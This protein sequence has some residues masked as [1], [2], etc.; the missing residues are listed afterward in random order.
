MRTI[1]YLIL[2]TLILLCSCKSGNVS[3]QES[4]NSKENLKPFEFPEIPMMYTEPEQRSNYLAKH[5]WENFNFADT[6]YVNRPEITEQAW[7]DYVN[8]L[9]YVPLQSA[10][11]YLTETFKLAEKETK[12]YKYFTELA[13]KYLYDP[14]SPFR[15]EE[16]YIAVLEVMIESKALE[17]VDKIR[18]IDRLET[19]KKNRVGY[20]AADF[21][22]T[23]ESGKQGS[24]YNIKSKYTLVYFNNPGCHACE[25]TIDQLK[26]S[27]SITKG[28]LDKEITILAI[29]PDEELDEWKKH[30]KDFPKEWINGYDKQQT[31]NNKRLYDLKAIPCLYFLD[32][33]KTVLLKDTSVQAIEEYLANH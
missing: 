14:N 3:G 27:M 11:Q 1:K 19:A 6:N 26:F 17:D 32:K 28:V 16:Y 18:P 2:F 15:N 30:L 4:N 24:L 31:L 5:Y 8:I 12:V 23:T 21:T 20:K 10:Q 29:Y 33:E 22:Y 13:D 25:E 9:S 7:V